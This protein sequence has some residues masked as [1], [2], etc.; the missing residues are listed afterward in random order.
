MS[1]EQKLAGR[2]VALVYLISKTLKVCDAPP[3]TKLM[4]SKTQQLMSG[5]ADR[6]FLSFMSSK[7]RGS[8]WFLHTAYERTSTEEIIIQKDGKRKKC[9][10]IDS[11]TK[12][13][14]SAREV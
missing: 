9:Q 12:S 5:T 11:E 13:V 3:V 1:P 7:N 14:D 6:Q 2:K 8:L 10:R 4:M